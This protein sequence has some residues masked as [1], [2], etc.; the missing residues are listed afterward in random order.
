MRPRI[1]NVPPGLRVRGLI[2]GATQPSMGNAPLIVGTRGVPPRSG[3]AGGAQYPGPNGEPTSGYYPYDES[4]LWGNGGPAGTGPVSSISSD[5]NLPASAP[6]GTIAPAWSNP[7]T[8]AQVGINAATSTSVPV[9][10]GNN[11]RRSLIIQNNSTAVF[12]DTTPVMYIGFNAV[13]QVGVSLGLSA[14]LGILF[15]YRVPRDSIYITFGTF[16]NGGG[17]TVVQGA[18]VQAIYSP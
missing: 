15:D 1:I 10:S 13:A 11:Q 3:F 2:P 12:P 9:L 4:G 14:G 18:V 8:F 7:D 17:T 16:V 5:P 6:A